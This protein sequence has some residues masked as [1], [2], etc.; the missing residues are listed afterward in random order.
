L[1][2]TAAPFNGA[3]NPPYQQY[4][5]NHPN[6][7]VFSVGSKMPLSNSALANPPPITSGNRCAK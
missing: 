1:S 6:S 5:G 2:A 7:S 3:A 4:M